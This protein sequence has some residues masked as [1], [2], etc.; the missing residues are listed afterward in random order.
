MKVI[1]TENAPKAIGPYSQGVVV[2]NTIYCSGQIPIVPQSGD[3]IVNDIEK[4][5]LQVLN[6]LLAIIEKA[7]GNKTTIIKCTIYTTDLSKFD[8]INR[9]YGDFF[10]DHKPARVTVEVSSLPKGVEVEID[11][12]AILL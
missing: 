12:V 4:A 10:G 7:G 6:N 5:T 1:K 3:V 2:G 9:V 11:A 8:I